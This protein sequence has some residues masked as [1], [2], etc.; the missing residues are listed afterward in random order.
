M[1]TFRAQ[2]ICKTLVGIC[3]SK[4]H[5][6]AKTSYWSCNLKWEFK[7]EGFVLKVVYDYNHDN[8]WFVVCLRE[9]E[10]QTAKFLQFFICKFHE[11]LQFIP[12]NCGA[13]QYL[14]SAAFDVRINFL[15]YVRLVT[16]LNPTNFFVLYDVQYSLHWQKHCFS[17]AK[18]KFWDL[19]GYI[20]WNC[21]L[22][23]FSKKFN[24]DI[25]NS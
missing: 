7:H 16:E 15:S 12:G 25:H 14:L 11:L 24:Q 2:S 13:L 6:F 8:C 4:A 20:H 9:S 17:K 18:S 22:H 23:N 19:Y 10:P 3:A 21:F 1:L 5:L